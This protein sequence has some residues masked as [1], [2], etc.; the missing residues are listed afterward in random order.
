MDMTKVF[1]HP[2]ALPYRRYDL[3]MP[4]K[5]TTSH[6]TITIS[7]NI[8]SQITTK[9]TRLEDIVGK[10]VLDITMSLDGFVAGP[11]ASTENP[12]GEGGIRLHDWMFKSQSDAD[13]KVIEETVKSAGAVLVGR[14]TYDEGIDSGWE[15]VSPFPAPAFV[16]S[17]SVPEKQVEGF[18]YV[19][20]G[21]ESAL[22]QAQAVAGDK[23]I[24]L[25]GGANLDQQY[26]KARL[27]DEIQLHI[28][29]VLF[30]EGRRLF[31]HIGSE[32][33]ELEKISTIDT[34]EATHFK[35]RVVK[36]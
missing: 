36:S 9:V 15:G 18:I 14:R 27:V 25:M 17:H 23:N 7:G 35:F 21:I 31:D 1:R 10:V 3:F 19:T 32:H 30:T 16:V 34:P 28:A 12:L 2:H 8:P 13:A 22:K 24:W 5:F 20:D 4:R 11:N 33:I 26:L 6:V 29:P